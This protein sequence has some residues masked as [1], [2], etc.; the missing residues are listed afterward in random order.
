MRPLEGRVA[1]VTAAGDGVGRRVALALGR[2]GARV[3]IAARTDG[4]VTRLAG[5]LRAAGASAHTVVG[6]VSVP[7]DVRS[8]VDEISLRLGPIDLL[9]NCS[10]INGEGRPRAGDRE[11]WW[12][13]IALNV[14][15][16]MLCCHAVLPGMIAAG[17]GHV[18]NVTGA[19]GH[20]AV[21]LDSAYGASNAA[22]FR[23]TE[24]LGAA[25][26]GTGVAIF[27]V[28]PAE[29]IGEIIVRLAAGRSGNLA[30]RTVHADPVLR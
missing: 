23:L 11:A 13:I 22:L 29:H 9:V 1:L 3:G 8:I 12:R 6:D 4:D 27:D 2:A 28:S 21:P 18:F 20:P 30:G 5:E 25:L 14:R 17:R 16:P 19:I 7:A 26:Q 15:G 24:S 10:E